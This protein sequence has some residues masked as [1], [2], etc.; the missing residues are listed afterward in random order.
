MTGQIEK[1]PELDRRGLREFGIITGGV[2]A[3]LFGVFFPW[4]LERAWPIWPWV[5]FGVLA[6]WGLTFPMTL[7][8]IYRLWMRFG[9]LMSRVTTPL[10]MGMVFFLAITPLGIIRRLLGK[11]SLNREFTDA[12]SYRNPSNKAPID[13]LKRPF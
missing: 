1:I 4:L 7:R 11:D 9:I 6:F 8:P 13:N 10:L 12:E 3:T 2:V 5:F